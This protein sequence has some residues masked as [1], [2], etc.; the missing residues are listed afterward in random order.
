MMQLGNL[1]IVA[2][3]HK[4]CMLQIY[5]NE[6]TVHT[7]QGTERKTISYDVRDNDYINKIGNKI[8]LE[9]DINR[10]IGNEWFRTKIATKIADK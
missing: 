9:Y 7:G 10:S 6:V 5:D 1:A 2:A 3:N 8:L 4:D